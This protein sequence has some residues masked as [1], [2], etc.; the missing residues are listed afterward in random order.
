MRAPAAAT[1]IAFLAIAAAGAAAGPAVAQ[2]AGA[3]LSIDG[4]NG[5]TTRDCARR[6]VRVNG[7]QNV[8]RL[9]GGCR[10]LTVSG[11]RNTVRAELAPGAALS[12]PGNDNVVTWTQ[13]GA[14]AVPAIADAGNRNRIEGPPGAPAP[15]AA[16]PGVVVVPPAAAVVTPGTVVTPGAVVGGAPVVV[17]GVVPAPAVP[18]VVVGSTTTAPPPLATVNT[19]QGLLVMIPNE[20]LFDFDSDA[21][22]SNAAA[23]LDQLVALLERNRPRGLRVVGHTDAVGDAAYNQGLS[24]RRARSVQRWLSERAG[25]TAPPIVIEGLGSRK[26][27]APNDTADNRARNRRVEVLLER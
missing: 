13:R 7:N 8:L 24:E 25:Y 12:L 10:S 3:V 16:A 4:N 2:P 17:P 18:G 15:A 21:L 19:P 11:N 22:R 14:G 27:V 20:V 1:A 23:T 5:A 6:D 9:T 26:P